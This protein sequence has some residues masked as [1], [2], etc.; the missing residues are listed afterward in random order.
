MPIGTQFGSHFRYLY[1]LLPSGRVWSSGDHLLKECKT[2][3]NLISY[4]QLA[5]TNS[6]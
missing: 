6:S 3:C 1:H 4:A 2:T 5:Y